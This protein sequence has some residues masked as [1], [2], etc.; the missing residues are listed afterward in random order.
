MN[1]E[2][3]PCANNEAG[4]CLQSNLLFLILILVG[5]QQGFEQIRRKTDCSSSHLCHE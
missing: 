2:C 3:H 5:F 1:R 4:S